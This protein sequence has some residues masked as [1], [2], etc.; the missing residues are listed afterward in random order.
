MQTVHRLLSFVFAGVL[1]I[2]IVGIPVDDH[3]CGGSFITTTIGLQSEDPCGD[4]PME[5]D[6]CEDDIVLFSITDYFSNLNINFFNNMAPA[7][8]V[9]N[10][11]ECIKLIP[12][13]IESRVFAEYYPPPIESKIFIEIQSF[14][15]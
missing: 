5:G 6:C 10:Y 7:V 2:S 1:L 9:C 12:E 11:T 8:L 15:L 3:Y 13:P 14:L 4:M